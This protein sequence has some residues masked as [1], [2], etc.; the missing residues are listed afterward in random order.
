M[1]LG[2][3]QIQGFLQED[4]EKAGQVG[5]GVLR[6]LAGG[7]RGADLVGVLG[8]ELALRGLLDA[9]RL[10][11]GFEV[12]LSNEAL[13]ADDRQGQAP[14]F[15]LVDE[16]DFLDSQLLRNHLQGLHVQ[17]CRFPSLYGRG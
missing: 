10:H 4:S 17:H 7:K 15:V 8:R 6:G 11:P 13:V 5:L 1:F 14:L 2:E 9:L 3:Y 12:A 16:G